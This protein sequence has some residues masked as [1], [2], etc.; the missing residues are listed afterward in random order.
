MLVICKDEFASWYHSREQMHNLAK[1]NDK[2]IDLVMDLAKGAKLAFQ[3]VQVATPPPVTH[4]AQLITCNIQ[5]TRWTKGGKNTLVVDDIHKLDC[6]LPITFQTQTTYI[7]GVQGNTIRVD[8]SVSLLSSSKEDMEI[9][10]K[11][12]FVEP[13]AMHDALF[14]AWNRYFQRDPAED[15]E[16]PPDDMM[17]LANKLTPEDV[18][19]FPEIN[20]EM[21]SR[22]IQT[23]KVRSARGVDGFSTMDLRKLPSCVMNFLALILQ[24]V[25]QFHVWPVA[26][27]TAKTICLP[28]TEHAESPFDIRPVTIT[29]KVYR[30]WGQVRGK[31][32][33]V[34]L[35]SLIPPQIGGPCKGIAADLISLLTSAKIEQ[36]LTCNQP[37]AGLVLDLIK[38]Y[39][40]VHRGILIQVMIRLGIP[41]KV[42][43]PF[44]AMM[45][46]MV[47]VWEV[48]MTCSQGQQTTTGIIEGCGFAVPAMLAIG[49]IFY[50]ILVIECPELDHAYFAD[51][52]SIFASNFQDLD[53][54]LQMIHE[55]A[56]TLKLQISPSKS[57]CW[58]TTPDL[59]KSLKNLKI[60]GMVIPVAMQAQD[61]G[62]Q[63]MYCKKWS[64]KTLLK[65]FEKAKKTM[66]TIQKVK[67]P[68]GCK[69]RLTQGAGISK[70]SYGL[71]INRVG[72][73]ELHSAR[74]WITKATQRSG[75][76]VNA[77]LGCNTVDTSIDPEL[78][79]I[80]QRNAFACSKDLLVHFQ[81]LSVNLELIKYR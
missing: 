44:K 40:T 27:T 47:R 7:V 23:T 30:L 14:H 19:N 81:K 50:K 21:L 29:A 74:T 18:A 48:C 62:A 68:R 46:Q 55:I 75:A 49:I 34:H 1:Q 20:G 73:A 24:H 59:R 9:S 37:L 77:F 28:K 67:V 80:Q 76:G 25:E 31:Q 38:A 61:L 56:K 11:Q 52:I 63:Q 70:F 69:K 71:A 3:K 16:Q 2:R 72:K 4:I 17:Q 32:A 45:R 53:N 13:T 43:T 42:L 64:K 60:G 35:S 8:P 26:W 15:L 66:K 12:I 5:H 10:Q 78:L 6:T 51:N 22:A 58:G 54:G 33:A 65:R 57:W 36:A 39:N 79:I 41:L